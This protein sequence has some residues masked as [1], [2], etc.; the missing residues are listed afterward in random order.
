M[1]MRAAG[2]VK[3]PGNHRAALA[4][5]PVDV[6]G[7]FAMSMHRWLS[8]L[9][10]VCLMAAPLGA[11]AASTGA[12]PS[13]RVGGGPL[14]PL[15][16]NRSSMSSGQGALLG[17]VEGLTEFLPISSTGH[18]AIVQELLGLTATPEEK[19]ASDAFAICIQAGAIIAVFL[20]S[21]GRIRKIV[22]GMFGRD[23]D[24][25][26]LLGNL[27]VAFVPA[28]VIGL[29]LEERIKHYLYGIWPI[30]AAWLVGGIFILAVLNRRRQKVGIAL[31]GLG[32]QS[33]LVIGLAQVLALWPGV[34]RSLVTIAG[35]MFV[36][37]SISA[38]VEFSFLLG[39]VTLGAATIYE[40]IRQGHLIVQAFGIASPV[41]GL[42]VAGVSA[43]AAVRWMVEYLRTRS[44]AVFGWYRIAAAVVAVILV[45]ARII[46]A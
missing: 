26:K 28:A 8:L 31:E 39:L 19:L 16:P 20:I 13:M 46:T 14:L 12:G 17:L 34:S 45:A 43:F 2:A 29:L 4:A 25:L 7:S 1:F 11:Q 32:W 3:S 22:S 5:E 21:F 44:L 36:G 40:G 30:A 6:V 10:L 42:I 24:G 15:E 18:L 41:I 37:L 33:A 35:G 23:K 9:A 27:A 38:A